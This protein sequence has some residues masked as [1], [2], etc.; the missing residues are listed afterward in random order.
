MSV[1]WI[2][3]NGIKILHSDNRLKTPE[4][5]MDTLQEVADEVA[6]SPEKVFKI[7]DFDNAPVNMK[8]LKFGSKLGKD[9]FNKNT[10]C[11]VFLGVS[12]LRKMYFELYKAAVRYPI[13][14]A[15]SFEEALDII[16]EK[17]RALD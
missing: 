17:S 7:V 6:S 4:Q 14:S 11:S 2:E 1:K 13:Y 9:V 10:A 3:H 5:I 8:I 16:S 12:G 15:S